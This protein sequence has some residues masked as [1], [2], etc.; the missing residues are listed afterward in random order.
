M[1]SAYV[2]CFNNRGTVAAAL[3][4]IR[5]QSLPV[6]ELLAVDDG[7]SDGSCAVIEQLGIRL[8]RH[9]RNLGRGAARARAMAE[10]RGEYVLCCDATNVLEPD[11]VKKALPWF[12]N[13]NV[14]AVVGTIKDPNPQ[15]AVRRWRAR[16]LFKAGHPLQISHFSPLITFGTMVRA[17][18][19]A[20]VGG[21]DPGM[22]HSEDGD[23]GNRLLARGFDI[24]GDPS[25]QIYSNVDNSLRQTLEKVHGAG[26]RGRAK[27]SASSPTFERFGLRGDPWPG[28]TCGT[29]TWAP[30]PSAFC[31]LTIN[32]GGS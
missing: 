4:S 6:T 10:S 28:A 16:H 26:M 20:E 19:V 30:P 12:E 5:T 24:V 2:P 25:L 3:E 13:E 21:Y 1:V 27:S 11:F 9:G 29:G 8:I 14:A 7:S 17:S 31:F 23:L 15:G 18:A 32:C 22:R